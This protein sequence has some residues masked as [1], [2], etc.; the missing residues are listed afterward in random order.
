M[1]GLTALSVVLD[2]KNKMQH[3]ITKLK[4]GL[5]RRS[6]IT[7]KQASKKKIKKPFDY[8]VDKEILD[9]VHTS[10]RTKV[11]LENE[12]EY[13]TLTEEAE[14]YM[15]EIMQKNADQ[16]MFNQEFGALIDDMKILK[17]AA[18]YAYSEYR[19]VIEKSDLKYAERFERKTFDMALEFIELK[20][21]FAVAYRS[22]LLEPMNRM[23]MKRKNIIPDSMSEKQFNDLIK[24][25]EEYAYIHN[26]VL[27]KHIDE[28][29]GIETYKIEKFVKTDFVRFSWFKLEKDDQS[30]K[31]LGNFKNTPSTE[32]IEFNEELAHKLGGLAIGL[33]LFN[34]EPTPGHKTNRSKDNATESYMICFDFEYN[35]KTGEELSIEEAKDIFKDYKYI[36]RTT[37]KHRKTNPETG[38]VYGDRFHIYIPYQYK[39]TLDAEEYKATY[40]NIA[41][42]F[43]VWEYI[44]QSTRHRASWFREIKEPDVVIYNEG[45]SLD[46]RCCI[47]ETKFGEQVERRYEAAQDADFRNMRLKRYIERVLPNIVEGNRDNVINAALHRIMNDIKPSPEEARNALELMLSI[48]E[49]YGKFAPN[50]A[51]FRKMLNKY[52]G[53]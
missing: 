8:E 50:S 5:F 19:F 2:D 15:Y 43:G 9:F 27:K 37:R 7:L 51:K 33:W 13:I 16:Q 38:E 28:T 49:G 29:S 6:F 36:L 24:D 14:E 1:L 34:P 18:I 53:E 45:K 31:T 17:L 22:M 26:S 32:P 46:Y 3:F 21:T 35:Q 39:M 44:D 10:K 23:I 41:K 4:Q 48:A 52:T 40:E 42:R 30:E 12:P 47:P 25:I 11:Y 20:N